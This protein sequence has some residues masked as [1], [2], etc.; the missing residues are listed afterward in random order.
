MRICALKKNCVLNFISK[1]FGSCLEAQR[2]TVL[3]KPWD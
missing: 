2:L 1:E 3:A